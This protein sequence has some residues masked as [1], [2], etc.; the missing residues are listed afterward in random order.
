MLNNHKIRLMTKLAIYEKEDGKEDIRLGRYY[1]GDYVRY[2]LLKTIVAVTCGYLILVLMTILYYME[3]LIA[4][5]V[6]LD[7]AAIGRTL[8]GSYLVLLLAFSGISML[9]YTIKYN[10]SRKKLAKYYRMLKRLRTIYREEKEPVMPQ[11]IPEGGWT[12]EEPDDD[13]TDR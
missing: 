13:G 11:G 1:R 7:Y 6:K 5:A 2:Q 4:E 10:R 9:G 8:L 3:Y 12:S